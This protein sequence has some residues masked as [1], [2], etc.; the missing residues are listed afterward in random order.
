MQTEA[1]T[2]GTAANHVLT[3][4][5]TGDFNNFSANAKD[6]NDFKTTYSEAMKKNAETLGADFVLTDAATKVRVLDKVEQGKA[7]W[8]RLL[9]RRTK[10]SPKGFCRKSGWAL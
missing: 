8:K 3:Q 7:V 10:N 2:E 5:G 4:Y 9:I 6:F 1:A